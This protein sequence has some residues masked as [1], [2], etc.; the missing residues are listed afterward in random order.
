LPVVSDEAFIEL[1][2]F[3]ETVSA[4]KKK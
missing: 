1:E 4:S 3:M 2:S